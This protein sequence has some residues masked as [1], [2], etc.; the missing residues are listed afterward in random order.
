MNPVGGIL[1]V[2]KPSGVTSFAVV[3]HVRRKLVQAY[4]E[5]VR[6]RGRRPAG[7]PKPPRFKCGHAG[8]L[9]PLAT[10]LLIVLV[11]RPAS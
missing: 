1:L 4:P 8:T 2:D 10:G 11:G 6:G 7:T 5:L 9:D 3:N